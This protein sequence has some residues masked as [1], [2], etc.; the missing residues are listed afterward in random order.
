[1]FVG[2][3]R[4]YSWEKISVKFGLFTIKAAMLV[5]GKIGP[6]VY[7]CMLWQL[8]SFQRIL[9]RR[10]DS[11]P[12]ATF[13]LQMLFCLFTSQQYFYRSNHRARFSAVQFGKV[14]PG[15]VF[16]GEVMHWT[17]LIF[18]LAASLIINVQLLP[19]TAN[20]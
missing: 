11:R 14:C 1:M 4:N 5:S 17:L 18:E 16:C 15:G 20:A 7:F 9:N 13:T 12:G 6:A 19:M 10:F 8:Y 2:M 3:I